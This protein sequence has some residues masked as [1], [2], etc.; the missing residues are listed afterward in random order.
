V[1]TISVRVSDAVIKL[2]EAL[3]ELDDPGHGAQII[4]S[5]VV[6]NSNLGRRVTGV[7]YD[8]FAPLAMRTLHDIC[9]EAQARWG[10]TL[11]FRVIHRTGLVPVGE[12]SLLTAVSSP[13]RD[14]AYK[15]SRYVIEQIK[16]R[17]PIW[18]KE[19]Y[20]DGESEWLKGHALCGHA[21]GDEAP[22]S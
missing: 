9:V 20:I 19:H 14:E 10:A 7:S 12:A 13:H 15:A 16:V 1:E 11:R 5:G 8:A 3:R 17:A 22:L 21:H 18:K 2:E 6:R 4:F